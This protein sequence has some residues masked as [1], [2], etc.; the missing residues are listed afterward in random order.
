MDSMHNIRKSEYLKSK[1]SDILDWTH[2]H[3]RTERFYITLPCTQG[4]ILIQGSKGVN[5]VQ[6]RKSGT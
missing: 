5:D 2:N 3:P 4:A 6:L 1:V